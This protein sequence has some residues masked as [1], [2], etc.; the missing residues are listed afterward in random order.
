[1]SRLSFNFYERV[2]RGEQPLVYIIITTAMGSR[3][4]GEKEL[5]GFFDTG[6]IIADGSEVADGSIIAGGDSLGLLEKSGR[7]ISVS[8]PERTIQPKKRDV[9]AAY[10]NKQQQNF[11]ARLDNADRH[12]SKILPQEYFLGRPMS[13]YAGFDDIPFDDHYNFFNGIIYEAEIGAN[14]LRVQANES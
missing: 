8:R 2:K 1:M 4:Y 13:G 9:L 7:I 12:F 10:T 3:A 14:I 5:K 6:G 11:S